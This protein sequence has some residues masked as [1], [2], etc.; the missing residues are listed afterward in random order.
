VKRKTWLWIGLGA[1]VVVLLGVLIAVQVRRGKGGRV[2]AVQLARVR[3]EDITSRV[4]APGKIEAKT[5]VKVSADIMGKIVVLAVKEGDR[6]RRGQLMLQ[7]DDRQYRAYHD[8]ARATAATARARAQEAQQALRTGEATY[9]RQQ[10]LFAEK[11]LSDAE[12]DQA[13]SAI[14]A[15]RAAAQAARQEVA[16]ADAAVAAAADNLRK[17]RFEAP[18]DGVVSALNVE[19]G[20]NVITGTMNNPGTEILVVSDLSRMLVRA[21]VD[22]TDVVDM[23]VGQKARIFVDAL[24]DTSFPGTVSEIGN[25][26][27]RSVTSTIEGQTNFEVKVVFDQD[28][29][30]VRP[31]MN[32]DVEVETGTHAKT[33]G[34]PIQA[35][36]VRTQSDLD[37]AARKPGAR[38]KQP[39]RKARG[40]EVTADEDTVGRKERE[41]TGVFV[42]TKEST[43][44]FVPVRTGIAGESSI[45]ILGDVKVGDVVV[46]GPY[47]ALRDLKPNARVKREAAGGRGKK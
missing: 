34:V 13:T 29:P 37:R 39:A 17:T 45:E 46:A 19:A 11:L 28:V 25:T 3:Q 1:L 21:D 42:V 7:L 18:F 31:G 14:E 12:W 35:V 20:E 15:V 32:A 2:E 6:V 4:R 8:Q 24:P 16:R 43:A 33:L 10:A 5:Q 27:K 9:R 40:L 38:V 23:R 47:K 44:R 41:I 26:A 22:E 30:A 36:V